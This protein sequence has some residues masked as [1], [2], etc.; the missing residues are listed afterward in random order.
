MWPLG[1]SAGAVMGL[2]NNTFSDKGL[3]TTAWTAALG[4]KEHR[5]LFP[6]CS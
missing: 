2:K 6:R 4:P 5:N 1:G 3:V